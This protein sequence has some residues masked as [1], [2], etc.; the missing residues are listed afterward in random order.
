ML[1]GT[2]AGGFLGKIPILYEKPEGF[3]RTKNSRSLVEIILV[4]I[5]LAAHLYI[6]LA[7]ANSLMNWFTTDDAFYYFKTAQNIGLGND[8]SFDGISRTNGFHPLWMIIC[9]PIFLLSNINLL[10]PL[11]IV[12]FLAGLM[13]AATVVLIWRL[14]RNNGAVYAGILT[15]MFWAFSIQVHTITVTLGMESTVNALTVTLLI[16]L[17]SKLDQKK[18]QGTLATRDFVLVGI[19]AIFTFLSRIDNGFVVG[20]VLLWALGKH[21]NSLAVKDEKLADRWLMRLRIAIMLGL[22]VGLTLAAYLGFNQFYFGTTMPV[23]GLIKR[24]WGTLPNTVYGFPVDNFAVYLT[25]LITPQVNIGPWALATQLP[26][27]IAKIFEALFSIKENLKTVHRIL[28]LVISLILTGLAGLLIKSNWKRFIKLV[29]R[30]YLIPF[31]IGCM[32]QITSYKSTTYIETL[33]WYWVGEMVFIALAAGVLADCMVHWLESKSVSTRFFQ[34]AGVLIGLFMVYQYGAYVMNLAPYQVDPEYTEAYLGGAHALEQYTEP[35]STIGTTGGGIVAYFIKDRKIINLDGLINSNEYFQ[36][37]RRGK[38]TEYFDKIGLDYVYGNIYMITQ[39][40]PYARMFSD[41]VELIG[42]VEGAS[43]F[44]YK[45][46][47]K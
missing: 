8:I 40:D 44:R 14:F 29:D 25:H 28:V 19:T 47:K 36:R 39:S 1:S 32:A 27:D 42:T 17:V 9:V 3:L 22:P 33:T 11:R 37:M 31:L 16:Y 10:L 23:S 2:I 18:E 7:P 12:V 13:N 34:V 43:L 45:P 41:R 6:A 20:A 5:I 26:H 24:W 4:A 30:F 21:W 15:A 38:T 35:G 46:S